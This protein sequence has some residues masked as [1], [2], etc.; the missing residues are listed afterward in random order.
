MFSVPSGFLSSVF[1]YV[2]LTVVLLVSLQ[3]QY[4]CM[5]DYNLNK[6][7]LIALK[8]GDIRD[9][10]ILAKENHCKVVKQVCTKHVSF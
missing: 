4:A 7:Y 5:L 3:V 2:V 6:Y 8:D 10:M 9:A 1:R